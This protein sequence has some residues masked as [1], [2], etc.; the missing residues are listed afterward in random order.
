MPLAAYLGSGT[1]VGRFSLIASLPKRA[2]VGMGGRSGVCDFP[3]IGTY[4]LGP[5]RSMSRIGTAVSLNRQPMAHRDKPAFA[6]PLVSGYPFFSILACSVRVISGFCFARC[7]PESEPDGGIGCNVTSS[8]GFLHDRGKHF[9]FC[10]GGVVRAGL[11]SIAWV[12]GFGMPGNRCKADR[13]L[14]RGR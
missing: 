5:G 13:L 14:V 11:S 8:N 10:K 12:A 6:H 3:C 7:S 9:Q 2:E 1:R 4:C